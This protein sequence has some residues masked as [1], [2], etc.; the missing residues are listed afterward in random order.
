MGYM[1]SSLAKLPLDSDIDLYI[2]V[3]NGG[4]RGGAQDLIEQNF[5]RLA[6]VVEA[7]L[8]QPEQLP[9]LRIEGQ[10]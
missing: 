6:D 9:H 1:L 7:R 3:I 2:F 8:E 4:W 5:A 10:V